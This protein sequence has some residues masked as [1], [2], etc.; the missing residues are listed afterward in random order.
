MVETESNT[1][2][3]VVCVP[4]PSQGHISPMMQL[5]KLLNSRGF[6][7]T[8]VNTE[9]NHR[10]L[11]RSR[12]HTSSLSHLPDFRFETIPDGLPP[13]DKDATQDVPA[14]SDSTRNN[15][16]APFKELL[17]KLDKLSE[18]PPVS[19]VISDGVMGFGREA[20]VEL[21]IPEVQFWTASA[22][23]FM[24]YLQ[25]GEL[26]RRGMAP[27]KDEEFKSDDPLLDTTIDWIPG[28]KNVRLKDIPYH[29]NKIMFDFMGSEAQ[30]CLKSSAIIFNTFDEFEHEVLEAIS[31][32]FPNIYTI[33]PR[34]GH[35]T[36]WDG[37]EVIPRPV[38]V[39]THGTGSGRALHFSDSIPSGLIPDGTGRDRDG[40]GPIPAILHQH[41]PTETPIK[42]LN[43]SLWKEDSKLLEWLDRWEP[44]SVV[45]VNYGS[46]TVM[47]D[48]HLKEFAWGLANSKHP[49]LWVVRP[50]VVK[51]DSIMLP[52]EFLKEVKD[53]GYIAS[54]A[55][56][57]QVLGH[58]SVA[59]FLTHCGWNSM[60]ETVSEGVPVICWPF[61]A[62]QQTNCGFA[63][64]SWGIGLEVKHDV[65]RCDIEGVIKDMMEGE[66][67]KELRQNALEWRK[68]AI[69]ATD[70][71]GASNGN[72]DRMMQHLLGNY[73]QN[74][75]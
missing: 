62:D 5:A 6:H 65:K 67:G 22:C 9:F 48:Q 39:V 29:P 26:L 38:P 44:N 36:G 20:A 69:E 52:D 37:I 49:F 11:V 64:G 46:V 17:I 30:N 60:L 72:F 56:Q 4:Y 68:K 19:C 74:L 66:K 75:C 41:I 40:T 57:E 31:L 43:P 1:Q 21:G 8:F 18:V 63:C 35:G 73:R 71:G 58:K 34:G 45:Y 10:R 59:V 70:I 50:D 7:I 25:Y 51:S 3:H 15:C 2:P 24:G 12:G 16:L 55:P 33:G 14:L 54:W 53:R 47:T 23:G 13:S 61:F 28:L 42:S 32:T 27:F